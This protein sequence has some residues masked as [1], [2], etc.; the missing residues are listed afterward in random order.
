MPDDTEKEFHIEDAMVINIDE[1]LSSEDED[2]QSRNKSKVD[3][4]NSMHSSKYSNFSD[5]KVNESLKGSILSKKHTSISEKP[6]ALKS[7]HTKS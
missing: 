5:N 1:L 6:S 3:G 7:H 4:I 2:N